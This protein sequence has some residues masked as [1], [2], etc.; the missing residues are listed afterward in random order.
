MFGRMGDTQDSLM[1]LD[2]CKDFLALHPLTDTE[3]T[4]TLRNVLHGTACDW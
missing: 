2:K 3:L 4:A 1:F